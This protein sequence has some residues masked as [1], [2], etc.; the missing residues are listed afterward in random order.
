MLAHAVLECVEGHG[1]D[2]RALL[3][4]AE[5]DPARLDD[6]DARMTS[7][8]YDRLHTAALTLT[9]HQALGL[10]MGE[11]V[12]A[13]AFDVFGD[14]ALHAPTLRAAVDVF[15]R[16]QGLVVDGPGCKLY[17][18]GNAAI[19]RYDFPRGPLA[20][21]R[22]RAEFAMAGVLRL[23]RRFAPGGPPVRAVFFE[24]ARPEY[25]REYARV[26]GGAERFEHEF[27]GIELDRDVLDHQTR[28]PHAELYSVLESLACRKLTRA[29]REPGHAARVKDYLTAHA[30][31]AI[32][33]MS[34]V[35]RALG[36]ST[37]SLRRRLA[38][39]D[40]SYTELLDEARAT[41]AKRLLEDPRRSI[42]ETAYAMGFSDATAFHRAFKRWTGLTP[43]QYRQ[44]A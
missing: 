44:S 41:A 13:A 23:I 18:Q 20:C 43:T 3:R 29:M 14:L 8:E 34:Q 17:E 36:V 4:A 38:E 12:S 10:Q 42:Y 22:L 1:V 31:G 15:E 19:F 39:E 28:P 32:P 9:R 6:I 37:R 40:V 24:H 26:F 25:D 27:T 30:L 21:N 16:F 33:H 35:A 2:R 11:N 7:D 5:F